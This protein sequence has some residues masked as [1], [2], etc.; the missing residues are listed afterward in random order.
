MVAHESPAMHPT[1]STE[2][3]RL[4]QETALDLSKVNRTRL[5]PVYEKRSLLYKYPELGSLS[6]SPL[7]SQVAHRAGAYPGF[8]KALVKRTGK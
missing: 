1:I 5:F 8:C 3:Q 4:I 2:E 6:L 7:M